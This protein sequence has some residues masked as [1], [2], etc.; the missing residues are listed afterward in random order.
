MFAAI[1]RSGRLP[2]SICTRGREITN[3]WRRSMA[4]STVG[5]LVTSGSDQR[6]I[7]RS[8]IAPDDR[9]YDQSWGP[10]I[11]RMINRCNLRPIV[12]SIMAPDDRSYDRSQDSCDCRSAI[13]DNWW[14]HHARLVVRSRKTYLRPLSI[15]NRRL[16]VLNTTID[17]AATEFALAIT[18]DL[19]DQSCVL[20]TICP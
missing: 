15:W 5:N 10:T 4:R 17:L 3:D 2:R 7:V 13:I 9:S 20:F 6:P 1:S 18:H 8:V 12:R 19:C 11:D 16:E 14:C